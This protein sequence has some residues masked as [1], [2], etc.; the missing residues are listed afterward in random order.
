MNCKHRLVCPS[1]LLIFTSQLVQ[2]RT[3]SDMV[4]LITN[5]VLQISM[6][7][8]NYNTLRFKKIGY[9]ILMF[10]TYNNFL[11]IH[12]TLFPKG[13]G[14]WREPQAFVT[15]K[16]LLPSRYIYTVS[17]IISPLIISLLLYVY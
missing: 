16:M 11:L 10:P 6:T 12:M 5:A 7:G 2:P 17:R 1:L 15:A 3:G 9:S 13:N 8:E 14:A 4:V